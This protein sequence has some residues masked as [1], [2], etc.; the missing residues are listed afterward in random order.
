MTFATIVYKRFGFDTIS[1]VSFI[2]GAPAF[3]TAD[4]SVARQV[5]QPSEGRSYW[6]SEVSVSAIMYVRREITLTTGIDYFNRKWGMNLLAADG[7][8]IWRR[9]RRVVGPAFNNDL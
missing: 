5:L 2:S 8:D 9:H 1:V 4:L 6:K 3:Y 7:G